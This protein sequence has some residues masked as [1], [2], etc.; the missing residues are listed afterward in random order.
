MT[1][2]NWISQLSLRKIILRLKLISGPWAQLRLSTLNVPVKFKL[3]RRKI[4]AES[5]TLTAHNVPDTLAA[6]VKIDDPYKSL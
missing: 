4:Y 3:L 2:P 6:F 1:L 5:A